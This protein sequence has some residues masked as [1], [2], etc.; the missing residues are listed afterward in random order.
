MHGLS[1][2]AYNY[3]REKFD[4]N[5]PHVSTI[6][7]W[8]Q[9][10][11]TCE[12]GINPEVILALGDLVNEKKKN[13]E[14]LLCSVCFDE[15]SIRRHVAWLN[16]SKKFSGFITYGQRTESGVFLPVANNVIV[17]LVTCLNTANRVSLPIAYQ[18]IKS[19]N[20]LEKS[21]LIDEVVKEIVAIGAIV[22]NLS[23]DGIA[24]NKTACEILGASFDIDD[25]RPYVIIGGEKIYC[26]F[27]SCHVTKLSRAAL[28]LYKKFTD[29][30]GNPIEFAHLERLE[31]RRTKDG[32]V[33]HKVTKKHIEAQD[34]NPMNVKLAVQLLSRSVANSLDFLN[35]CNEPGFTNT[36]GTSKFV[37]INNDLFDV[38]NTKEVNT[39]N[40]MKS[41]ITNENSQRIFNFF[42]EAIP[43]IKTLIYKG[44]PLIQSRRKHGFKSF[45]TNIHCIRGLCKDYIESKRLPYLATFYLMQDQLESLFRVRTCYLGAN[46]NPSM[47]QFASA[48]R[49]IVTTNEIKASEL[50]NCRDSL[51]ILTVSSS[52]KPPFVAKEIIRPILEC[53]FDE[54]VIGEEK[55]EEE[56]E[57]QAASD[58]SI[59]NQ[60][61]LGRFENVSMSFVASLIETKIR[62]SRIEC[63]YCQSILDAIFLSNENIN[64]RCVENSLNI[65]PCKSTLQICDRAHGVFSRHCIR[66]GFSIN[67]DDMLKDIY[68]DLATCTIYEESDF[69]HNLD[70]KRFIIQ[71]VT[72][73]YIRMHA[74]YVAK[75][76][77][78]DEQSKMY[79]NYLKK[80]VHFYGQ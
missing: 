63:K 30:D 67:Y 53:E 8:Y 57:F 70:H 28:A 64:S 46:D 36:E 24:T 39:S 10:S 38:F 15:M 59:E 20:G 9:H 34:R 2:R 3:V 56:R 14:E 76:L 22:V 16:T 73:E 31:A 69:S 33:T 77:T 40:D 78:L 79:R 49:K 61:V 18:G 27:D 21:Q 26:L 45:I 5:L 23:F 72:E 75:C 11:N 80:K 43:Y 58:R 68:R 47:Q 42:D 29:S 17:F 12:P 54:A 55:E 66:D 50:A 35:K 6:R 13:G 65:N 7:K 52:K 32:L 19:L 71:F 48:L 1:P 44:K 37:R 60:R 25:P 62:K 4:K 41:A 51:S 74:T